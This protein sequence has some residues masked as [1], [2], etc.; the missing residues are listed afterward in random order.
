MKIL[1]ILLFNILLITACT[2]NSTIPKTVIPPNITGIWS[3]KLKDVRLTDPAVDWCIDIKSDGQIFSYNDVA[4]PKIIPDGVG[5]WNLNAN[6]FRAI[7]TYTKN[8][9]TG[10]ST[11]SITFSDG[12]TKLT[13][14]EGKGTNTSGAYTFTMTKK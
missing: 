7:I 12:F 14:T 6:I 4:T 11:D 10:I 9:T 8:G 2:K 3:G 5:V 13:G 1:L